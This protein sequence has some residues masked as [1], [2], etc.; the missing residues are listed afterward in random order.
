LHSSTL[1]K[2]GW[3]LLFIAITA[4]YFWGL[5]S[6]PLV[7]P[8]EPRYAQVARE[9]LA[10][11]DLITPTLG[12][13]PWFEKPPLLYWLMMGSYRLFGINEYA[14]RFGPALCG[15]LSASSVYFAGRTAAASEAYFDSQKW[16]DLGPWSAL[17][18]LSSLGAIVFSRGASFDIV[19]TATITTAFCLFLAWEVRQRN[20]LLLA[21]FYAF[22]G[23]SFLAKGLIGYLIPLGVI[24]IYH[25]ARRRGPSRSLLKS[26]V[27]GIPL[28]LAVAGVWFV[29]MV[30]R[31][32]WL[33]I[34]Q[35]IVQHHFARFVS[36]KYHHPGPFYFYLPVL[37]G[38]SVPWFMTLLT[39]LWA[40]RHWNWRGELAI[41]RLRVFALI[42]LA[43]PVIFFSF[44]GSKLTAYIL[45]VLPAVALLAGDRVTG[46][47]HANR[48]QKVLRLTGFLLLILTG[49]AVWILTR[50]VHI[51]TYCAAAAGA[52][53]ALV[54]IVAMT[55]PT[56]RRT[57]FVSIGVA[58]LLTSTVGLI[59]AAPTVA[60]KESVRDLLAIATARGYES[61]PVV[62]LHTVERTAE[63]YAAGRITYKPDGEPVKLEGAGQVTEASRKVNGPV[64][65]F[66]PLEFLSQ[67]T[68]AR[69][70]QCEV[71]GDNGRVA[72]VLVSAPPK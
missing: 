21:G 63:F 56:I 51:P 52:P 11:G 40:S 2:R 72:L 9:M 61:A 46:L 29:P 8:D 69:N 16:E 38:L 7:G 55:Y 47:L 12:G 23:L 10:R 50:S 26:L 33:F 6:L 32:G 57:L 58:V 18:W 24:V 70:L 41:D 22:V 19:L 54:S 62:Q 15:L 67:L 20:K 37:I 31:H 42:W 59:C 34:D 44:S 28:A 68:T 36:N 3:L 71:L 5:G 43:L 14:A 48:G 65:C 60:R 4:F 64:L 66:V 53:L 49:A 25:L 27:W 45:P 13:L 35:F 30:L 17:V 39:S 1:A